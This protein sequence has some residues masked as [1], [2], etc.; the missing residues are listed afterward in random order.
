MK[1]TCNAKELAQ[2]LKNTVQYKKLAI[3]QCVYLDT[4]EGFLRIRSTDLETEIRVAIPARIAEYGRC[5]IPIKELSHT[6]KSINGEIDMSC[7]G[8]I[9]T[10]YQGDM[11]IGIDSL[12]PEDFPLSAIGADCVHLLTMEHSQLSKIIDLVLPFVAVND[13]RYV[14]N[15]VNIASKNG[16]A[17]FSATDG[18]HLQLLGVYPQLVDDGFSVTIPP[19]ALKKIKCLKGNTVSIWKRIPEEGKPSNVVYFS[20]E[21]GDVLAT[22]DIDGEYPTIGRFLGDLLEQQIAE[23]AICPKKW[24]PICEQLETSTKDTHS[25]ANL[26]TLSQKEGSSLLSFASRKG[27]S[28]IQGDTSHSRVFSEQYSSVSLKKVLKALITIKVET[29]DMAFV[30]R[31][32]MECLTFGTMSN[33]IEVFCMIPPMRED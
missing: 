13:T 25:V 12:A 16:R 30:G 2:A 11:S 28:S 27:S 3:T 29:I 15:G 22:R 23:M 26:I 17:G 7:S 8:D 10:I 33:G 14:L 5:V 32:G 21:S 19:S 31:N 18:C 9:A 1:I 24:L 4:T 20:T 6:I